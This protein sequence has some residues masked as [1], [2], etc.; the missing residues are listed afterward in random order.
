MGRVLTFGVVG[1]EDP[2][3][4]GWLEL[5]ASH[6]DCR[7]GPVWDSDP[8]RLGRTAERFGAEP[9]PGRPVGGRP[10]TGADYVLHHPVAEAVIIGSAPGDRRRWVERAVQARKHWLALGP[11]APFIQTFEII[12]ART[13]EGGRTGLVVMPLLFESAPARAADLVRSGRVG[14]VFSVLGV[15]RVR[16][17]A[18]FPWD[19]FVIPGLELFTY[20]IS[21]FGR[22]RRIYAED[23]AGRVVSVLGRLPDGGILTLEFGRALPPNIPTPAETLFEVVGET[24]AFRVDGL[25]RTVALFGEGTEQPDGNPKAAILEEFLRL[26]RTSDPAERLRP[27][28][29]VFA[30]YRVIEATRRSLGTGQTVEISW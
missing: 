25:H 24:G 27:L 15:Y 5:V 9:A 13:R 20:I 26:T 12:Y 22:P 23:H 6:P 10:V 16:R 17:L 1:L 18:D 4:E 11:F 19:P 2:D 30:A 28:E 14:R 29:L 8:D 3:V 21:A 7:I